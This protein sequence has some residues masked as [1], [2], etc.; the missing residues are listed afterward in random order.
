MKFRRHE[1]LKVYANDLDGTDLFIV[2]AL[3]TET[4]QGVKM[5][6]EFVARIIINEQERIGPRIREYRI[7]SPA[8]QYKRP[9]FEG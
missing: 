1:V 8:P 5:R 9:F 3:D 6:Q 7:V 2:G 4:L